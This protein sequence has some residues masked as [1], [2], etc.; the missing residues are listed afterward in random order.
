MGVHTKIQTEIQNRIQQTKQ[1]IKATVP[2]KLIERADQV[3][4][5]LSHTGQTIP[6]LLKQTFK[7]IEGNPNDVIGRL[8]RTVIERAE[9]VRATLSSMSAT[10]SGKSEVAKSDAANSDEMTI[11]STP[12]SE[13]SPEKQ[14]SKKPTG[15][16]RSIK[17]KAQQPGSK[18]RAKTSATTSA[19][20]AKPKK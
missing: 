9:S 10:A 1:A 15:K 20:K 13:S 16:T 2:P 11:V 12:N 19:T 8:S 7:K 3:L 5:G 17:A 4:L 18:S 6:N 14:A